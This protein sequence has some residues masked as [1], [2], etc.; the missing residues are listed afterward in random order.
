[1]ISNTMISLECRLRCINLIG[2]RNISATAATDSEEGLFFSPEPR[3]L[4]EDDI[5][6]SVEGIV[7]N[8]D[9]YS[10]LPAHAVL[11]V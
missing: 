5:N 6:L 8:L 10:P 3:E 9:L 1:V 2:I 4:W 7:S 11:E